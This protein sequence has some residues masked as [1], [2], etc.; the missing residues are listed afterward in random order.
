MK[1]LSV[2]QPWAYL[3]LNGFKSIELRTWASDYRG[4]LWLHSGKKPDNEALDFYQ[5][6]EYLQ[7]ARLYKGAY[8]GIIYL[9]AIVPMDRE[10]WHIWRSQHMD[11]T[12]YKPN[13]FGWL[14]KPVKVFEHPLEGNGQTLLF[15]PS[16]DE[17]ALLNQLR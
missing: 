7:N 5:D 15:S 17:I 12:A 9:S 4:E 3:I 16:D 1:A 13:L 11:F 6:T 14:V 10:R 8:V 2:K